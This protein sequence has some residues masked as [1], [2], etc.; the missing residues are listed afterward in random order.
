MNIKSQLKHWMAAVKHFKIKTKQAFV[1]TNRGRL[2]Y[3]QIYEEMS[4]ISGE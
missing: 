1:M 3:L 2:Y 4:L